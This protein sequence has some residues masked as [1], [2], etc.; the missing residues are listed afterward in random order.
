[1]AGTLEENLY[2]AKGDE[3]K[4]LADEFFRQGGYTP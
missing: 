1:V 2:K 3:L 4:K